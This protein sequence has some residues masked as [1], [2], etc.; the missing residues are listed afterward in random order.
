[1]PNF[2]KRVAA[3]VAEEKIEILFLN[4]IYNYYKEY[5]YLV[6][7]A[8]CKKIV[9]VHNLNSWFRPNM[10]LSIKQIM[11]IRH[12]NAI[13]KLSDAINVFDEKL[14]NYMS[15]NFKYTKNIF[16]IP[17]QIY[18]EESYRREN[19]LGNKVVN[20]IIPGQIEKGRKDHC[21]VLNVFKDIFADHT[22]ISITLLG[23]PIGDYGKSIINKCKEM[24]EKNNADIRFYDRYVSSEEFERVL[25]AAD[26][27]INPQMVEIYCDDAKT[28]EI[29]GITKSVGSTYDLIHFAKPGIFPHNIG[30]PEDLE[31][32]I[33]RYRDAPELKTLILKIIE[34]RALLGELSQKAK[35]NSGKYSLRI[36][37][38]KVV[39]QLNNFH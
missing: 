8:K 38:D 33:L 14:K 19:P 37:R 7:D 23:S 4:S 18:K 20:F 36:V 31:D 30:V 29:Y 15:E 2:L 28:T 39:S 16:T 10:R 17:F 35:V 25:S 26:I 1:M 32:S 11:D 24:I 22:N 12:K 27:I 3:V 9:S 21:L 5:F 34:D 13:I 6:R